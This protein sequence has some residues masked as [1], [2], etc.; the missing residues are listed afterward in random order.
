MTQVL[1][2]IGMVMVFGMTLV[3]IATVDFEETDIGEKALE[4]CLG[5]VRLE[6]Y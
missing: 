6:F 2:I 4:T 5:L 1:Q 3:I